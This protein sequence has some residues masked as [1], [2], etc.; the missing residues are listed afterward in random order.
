M[1]NGFHLSDRSAFMI[2]GAIRPGNLKIADIVPVDLVNS[3]IGINAFIAAAHR[4]VFVLLRGV[5][6]E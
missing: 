5:S 2:T 3:G 4:P 1:I 6:I